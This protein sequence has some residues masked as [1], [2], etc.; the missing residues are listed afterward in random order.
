MVLY[1]EIYPQKVIEQNWELA[2]NY[3]I[4]RMTVLEKRRINISAKEFE[5]DMDMERNHSEA[6]DILLDII[7]ELM[8]K[9][10]VRKAYLGI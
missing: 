9:D 7:E 8:K 10:E 1:K 5:D 3:C 2:Y 6:D 4:M